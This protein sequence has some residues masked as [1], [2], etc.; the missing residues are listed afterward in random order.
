MSE[1]DVLLLVVFLALMLLGARQAIRT[2]IDNHR[3]RKR[4]K[5]EDRRWS[6]QYGWGPH[7]D[8]ED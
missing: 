6:E 5:E 7:G 3:D 4:W 1:A 8:R 2:L